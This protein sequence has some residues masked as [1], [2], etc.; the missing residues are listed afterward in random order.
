MTPSGIEPATFRLVAQ[1][2]NEQRRRAPQIR[3]QYVKIIFK[4]KCEN[5]DMKK[6]ADIQGHSHRSNAPLRTENTERIFV[7]NFGRNNSKCE[8]S[9]FS[10][11]VA[12]TFAVVGCYAELFG[13]CLPTFRDNRTWT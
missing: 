4:I 12:E 1:C 9:G 3:M 8:L 7:P 2:L 6:D 11:G 13:S 5:S 10:R